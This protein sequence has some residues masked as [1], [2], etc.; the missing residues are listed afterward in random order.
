MNKILSLAIVLFL[1][2]ACANSQTEQATPVVEKQQT[3]KV[4]P[5]PATKATPAPQNN[6]RQNR[7]NVIKSTSRSRNQIKKEF[8]YDIDLKDA[9]GQLVSSDK[10]LSNDKPTILLFWLT[11][12]YPCRIEMDAIHKKYASWQEE[13]DFNL[14]AISTD[15][16]KNYEKF[17]ERVE[18]K[19]F[20]WE[21]YN[22]VNRE[23][24]Y[25][26]PGELNGLPQ[27]FIIDKNGQVAYHKR[28][29]SSGDEDKL[30]EKVKEL[31]K[32]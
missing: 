12:C 15:F 9:K 14:V 23:F 7:S 16:Q 13:T 25:V 4:T 28:K 24:R 30:Y 27:T 8:P 32:M 20:G 2:N 1:A 31:A 22:D 26:M 5:T 21:M 6:I 17:V 19:N 3:E 10:I 29:Y 18:Q 11:T